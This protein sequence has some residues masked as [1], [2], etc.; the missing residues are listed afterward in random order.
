[1]KATGE[2]VV[3]GASSPRTQ[4]EHEARYSFASTFV[5]GKRVLDI[6][7]GTGYA[8]PQ[9]LGAGARSYTGVDISHEAINFAVKTYGS[10]ARARF[11]QASADDRLFPD[12]SFDLICSFETIEHLDTS[13]R[14]AYLENLRRWLVPDGALIL[15]TP[16]KKV[17]SPFTEKPLNPFHVLEYRFDALVREL[18]PFFSVEASYGQRLVP[19]LMTLWLLRR[20]VRLCEIV[21][22]RHFSLYDTPTGPEVVSYNPSRHE[23][24]FFVLVC[25]PKKDATAVV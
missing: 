1:M 22:R 18:A 8:A 15:S 3:L 17:T 19:K 14:H 2:Q 25:R 11:I 13:I 7:C 6:A 5:E 9:F 12:G 21:F 4:A 10:D 23:P 16:N 20:A 24:R